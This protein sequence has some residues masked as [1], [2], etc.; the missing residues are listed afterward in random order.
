[1]ASD[2]RMGHLDE[3]IS[4]L[5]SSQER[6]NVQLKSLAQSMPTLEQIRQ[7]M[8]DLSDRILTQESKKKTQQS[9]HE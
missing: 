8:D 9:Y 7:T 2:K 4:E 3:R 1:M 5:H 6:L